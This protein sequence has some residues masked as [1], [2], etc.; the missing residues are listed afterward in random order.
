[1]LSS[2]FRTLLQACLRLKNKGD[3]LLILVEG[4]ASEVVVELVVVVIRFVSPFIGVL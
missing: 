2:S 3:F 1:M 4:L